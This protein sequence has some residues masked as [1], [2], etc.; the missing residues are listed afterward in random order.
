MNDLTQL[1]EFGRRLDGAVD[2]AARGRQRAR[3]MQEAGARAPERTA[4]HRR[5]AV[6]RLAVT[7]ASGTAVAA[8]ALLATVATGSSGSPAYAAQRL[9]DGTIKV[10][11]REFRDAPGL[12]RRLRSL[13]VR[14]V[15]TYLPTGTR[16]VHTPAW[17]R[18]LTDDRSPVF[19]LVDKFDKHHV[20]VDYKEAIVHPD[21]IP[22]GYT[23]YLEVNYDRAGGAGLW[24]GEVIGA[25]EAL[26]SGPADRCAPTTQPPP[27]PIPKKTH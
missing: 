3:L 16:C 4:W 15:I 18:R 23:V 13:G 1:E 25:A 11:I 10:T 7:A 2:V 5:P 24:K 19:E 14:A 8:A 20:P 12:E 6:R 27:L 21:R 26:A 9:P 17:Q 22:A